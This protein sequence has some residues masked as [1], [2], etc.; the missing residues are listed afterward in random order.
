[1]VKI[2]KGIP[3]P[4]PRKGG[5]RGEKYPWREMSVGDSFL[6][7]GDESSKATC[8][9]SSAGIRLGRKFTTRKTAEGYR[10]WRIE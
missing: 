1:M 4:E 9:A 3:I 5:R 10:I 7:D 2:D 6:F 8:A